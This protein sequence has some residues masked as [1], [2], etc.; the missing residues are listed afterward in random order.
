MGPMQTPTSRLRRQ[1]E[2]AG[3]DKV[4]DGRYVLVHASD[5][6]AACDE[7]QARALEPERLREISEGSRRVGGMVLIQAE[8]I[9]KILYEAD[10]QTDG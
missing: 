9:R 1:L 7:L 6:V 10:L 2:Y 4:P 8:A 3:G 5:V